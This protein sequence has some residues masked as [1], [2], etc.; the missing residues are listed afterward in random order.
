MD[1]QVPEGFE[2][3]PEGLGFTDVLA[4]VYAR[5]GELPALGMY[6]QERH[7]NLIGICHGGVLM[8]LGDIAAARAINLARGVLGGSPTLNLSFDFINAVR[9]GAWI[10]AQPDRVEV[11]RRVGFCSGV[12][13]SDDMTVCR[14]SG[15]FYLP[16][17]DGMAP[18]PEIL[19]KLTGA[20]AIGDS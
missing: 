16:D 10:Q 5:A 2:V 3:L 19:A 15:S 17:H 13:L 7:T 20:D 14:F 12:V 8:T 11:K 4:P 18:R 9:E 1:Q 6:V